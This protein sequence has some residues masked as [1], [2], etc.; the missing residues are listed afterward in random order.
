MFYCFE[1]KTNM[2]YLLAGSDSDKE[3]PCTR[4]WY[5]L[6]C[7]PFGTFSWAQSNVLGTYPLTFGTFSWVRTPL[8]LL[9]SLGYFLFH[10]VCG[11]R[12][13]VLF[14]SLYVAAILHKAFESVIPE[15]HFFSFFCAKH[16]LLVASNYGTG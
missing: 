9:R 6:G 2:Y 1:E 12:V 7:V 16:H 14:T 3:K 13:T 8:P 10:L 5:P 11:R 15:Q 4:S